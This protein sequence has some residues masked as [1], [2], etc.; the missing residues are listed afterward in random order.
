MQSDWLELVKGYKG[1]TLGAE[2]MEVEEGDTP[3][4]QR[5]TLAIPKRKGVNRE[6]MEEVVVVGRMPDKPEPLEIEYEWLD[7]YDND[8]Y[9]LLIHLSKDSQWPIRL[10]FNAT[11]AFA[12]DNAPQPGAAR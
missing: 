12:T 10:Y 1:S 6:T 11:D 2:L 7:D 9:G 8:R 5:I 3:G 4:T